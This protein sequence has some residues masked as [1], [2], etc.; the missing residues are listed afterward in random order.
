MEV[1]GEVDDFNQLL[2]KI[3]DPDIQDYLTNAGSVNKIDV[4]SF[5]KRLQLVC[6]TIKEKKENEVCDL[7]EKHKIFY[8]DNQGKQEDI[9]M[10]KGQCLN[11]FKEH[12]TYCTNVYETDK[13]SC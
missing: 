5:S 13:K 11:F 8:K 12:K 10:S 1:L 7:N 9:N 2:R 4:D 3:G 6:K